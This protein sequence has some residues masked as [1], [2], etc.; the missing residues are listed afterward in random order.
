MNELATTKLPDRSPVRVA[1]GRATVRAATPLAAV[2]LLLGLATPLLAHLALIAG[3]PGADESLAVVPEFIRL[4]FTEPVEVGLSSI[5]L[6][7]PDGGVALGALTASDARDEL[8]APVLGDLIAGEYTVRWQAV[9]R[10]G[11]PVRGEY[12]FGIEEDAEGLVVPDTATVLEFDTAA[13]APAAPVAQ[14]P[15]FSPQSPLYAGIRWL[16]YLGIIGA[17]GALGFGMLL[18]TGRLAGGGLPEPLYSAAQNGAAGLGAISASLLLMTLPLRLQAQSHAL[19]GGGVTGDRFSLMAETLWGQ[20]WMLQAGGVLLMLVGLLLVRRIGRPGWYLA[21]AGALPLAVA[22]GMSGHAAS[23]DSSPLLA[24]GSDGL[25]LLAAGV[26]LGTLVVIFAIGLPLLRNLESTERGRILFEL[27]NAFSPVALVAAGVLVATGLYASFLHLG[28]VA[29]LWTT[30]YGRL[31]LAKLLLVAIVFA[32]GA[33]NWRRLRPRSG[34]PGAA[35][36]L[37]GSA[38]VELTAAVLVVGLTSFLVAV[39]PPAD[40][41]E[42]PATN[43]GASVLP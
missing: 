5:V 4:S 25:H 43:S 35:D 38:A 31:L 29:D 13:A 12:G 27:V 15:S 22:P 14:Q 3:S 28:A 18:G 24:I 42:A 33:F 1:G 19:F 41:L 32:T 39:P 21:A 34:D 11:H 37:R 20:A 2:L 17:V 23:V 30:P 9:G 16:G 40:A 6:M 26:W 7:G 36:Q 10:D 8:E